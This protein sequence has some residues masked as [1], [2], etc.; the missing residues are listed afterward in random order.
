MYT[1]TL[2]PHSP[3]SQPVPGL[4]RGD[5]PANFPPPVTR[6]AIGRI[7]PA[8]ARSSRL[9]PPPR[10]LPPRV[11][12]AAGR[13]PAGRPTSPDS[14]RRAPSPP[15]RRGSG[16]P[17]QTRGHQPQPDN[18]NTPHSPRPV[19]SKSFTYI[20]TY[21]SWSPSHFRAPFCRRRPAPSGPFTGGRLAYAPARV[22]PPAGPPASRYPPRKGHL[23]PGPEGPGA[24]PGART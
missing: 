18:D 9:L 11:R 17:G 23:A 12:P 16:R 1:T 2:S 20:C 5:F 4:S 6:I 14:P 24:K 19:L 7:P 3:A 21:Q 15:G 13:P 22:A 10:G 8:L